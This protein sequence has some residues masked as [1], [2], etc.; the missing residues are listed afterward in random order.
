MDKNCPNKT[1]SKTPHLADHGPTPFVAN[2]RCAAQQNRT[3][4]TTFW[5]GT[6]LQMTLMDIPAG[7]SIGVEVHPD[8]DQ[9]IRVE[10]GRGLVRMGENR[11][12]LDDERAVSFGDGIFVP[13]G[14]WHN[15]FNVGN[16]PLKLSSIYAPP[17]HERATV[18][19]SK[20]D[21]EG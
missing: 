5:T 12:K 4:R 17:H 9:Y 21:A 16:S 20:A 15:I 19:P 7:E 1:G 10:A 13:A 6:H 14:T 2:I 11:D 18:H 3:F 8:T